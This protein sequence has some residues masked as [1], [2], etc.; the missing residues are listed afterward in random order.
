MKKII[1]LFLGAALALSLSACDAGSNG[2]TEVTIYR[3]E[4]SASDTTV[5]VP[6]TSSE[7]HP[8]TSEQTTSSE[9]DDTSKTEQ[10][11]SETES[12]TESS[13]KT[14]SS[15]NVSET[16]SQT[17][18]SVQ[19]TE[20]TPVVTEP[21]EQ[22]GNTL[23]AY[24]SW[25]GN[26]REM[27][28]YIAKQTDGDIFEIIPK[29]PYP[30]NYTKCTEVALAERDGDMRPEIK[31]L[32]DNIDEYDT[33][34][35]GYPIWWHTAPMIIGTFLES[36]DLTDV[37][38]YPFTQSASM[39]KEQFENSMDFVRSCAGNGRVHDGL[40]ASASNTSAIDSYLS[41]NGL[42]R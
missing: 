27:A 31:D 13:E 15:E 42:I 8:E 11:V 38:V 7:Q 33:L 36:Y 25:S 41:E 18:S 22:S 40:F 6:E 10:T 17:E 26:T 32:P 39:N 34:I 9:A 1:T 12:K 4:T 5:N 21:E 30:E 24:F 23:V 29:T 20:E 14:T 37:E 16:E 3:P 28:E 2:N 19:T 35:I